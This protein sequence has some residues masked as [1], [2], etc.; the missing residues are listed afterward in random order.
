MRRLL[1]YALEHPEILSPD[2]QKL[3]AAFLR[4]LPRPVKTG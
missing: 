3:G 1:R 2:E 4:R